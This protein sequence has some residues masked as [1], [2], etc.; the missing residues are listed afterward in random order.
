[1]L[2]GPDQRRADNH[3]VD[4]R[5]DQPYLFVRG[6]AESGQD[7]LFVGTD[8]LQEGKA[9]L[10]DRGDPAGDYRPEGEEFPPSAA[11][12]WIQQ[13]V[14]CVLQGEKGHVLLAFEEGGN[15]LYGLIP[16]N[17]LHSLR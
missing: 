4:V 7:L 13:E 9:L 3:R 8:P 16:F 10:I 2:N 1:M 15:V 12:S 17:F 6:H 5:G 11:L 14:F